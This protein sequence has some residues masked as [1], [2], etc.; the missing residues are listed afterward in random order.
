LDAASASKLL[1]LTGGEHMNFLTPGIKL[2]VSKWDV[3]LGVVRA[4]T[5]VRPA[6]AVLVAERLQL[7]ATSERRI[8]AAIS[9]GQLGVAIDCVPI[10]ALNLSPPIMVGRRTF[11]TVIANIDWLAVEQG[12]CT[13]R[14]HCCAR[15]DS[16]SIC[17]D[18]LGLPAQSIEERKLALEKAWGVMEHQL[19]AEECL[20]IT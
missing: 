19:T 17:D 2:P 13:A 14:Y 18:E 20:P 4:L 9:P 1:E 7:S 8:R 3:L 6:D 12:R 10:F 15:G 16:S 11:R 5:H